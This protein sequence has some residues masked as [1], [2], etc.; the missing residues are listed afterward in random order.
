M[1]TQ[2]AQ[3]LRPSLQLET[4]YVEKPWGRTD[5]P[6]G[7]GC[8]HGRRIGEI[9][10]EHDAADNLP[11]L[12]KYLF[13]SESL[14][15]QVHPD[16]VHASSRGFRRGKSE[17]WYILDAAEGAKI[18]LGLTRPLS[19]REISAAAS[20]GSIV[21]LLDWRPVKAGD[22]VLVP[23][24][25]IHAIGAGVSLLEMQQNLNVAYRLYDYGR[26]RELHVDEAVAVSSPNF[27]L[28]RC[29]RPAA[30]PLDCILA[31]TRHFS[32]VRA[33][34]PEALPPKFGGRRR[35]VMPIEGMATA[36]GISVSPGGCLLAEAG[37]ALT[38]SP[39]ALVLVGVE[40]RI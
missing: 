38:M 35:W 7:F 12:V 28:D 5:L 26:P 11:L 23:A 37:A 33:T 8:R 31:N 30:G 25:T 6:L 4:R 20:D 36:D 15:I 39:S 2:L 22:F 17:S 13:T 19:A 32:L 27:D 16:E 9:W 18:G 10:F 29:F 14:S 40:G 3:I 21:D 34:S 24:G 1:A